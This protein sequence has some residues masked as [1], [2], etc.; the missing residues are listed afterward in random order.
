MQVELPIISAS[1][2]V[3]VYDDSKQFCA[4]NRATIQDTC[5]VSF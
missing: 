2:C 1:N 5:G 3:F 4:G